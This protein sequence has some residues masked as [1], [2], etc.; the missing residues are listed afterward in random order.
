MP[1][2]SKVSEI[3]GQ[4][5]AVMEKN[6]KKARHTCTKEYRKKK[7]EAHASA[8]EPEALQN[9]PEAAAPEDSE[10]S[11][12]VWEISDAEDEVYP[13]LDDSPGGGFDKM[14]SIR[15]KWWLLKQWIW[16]C[17]YTNHLS[18]KTTCGR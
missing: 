12:M 8:P 14:Q 5:Q 3:A 9:A 10:K 4:L 2:V 18:T 7:A 11:T 1:Q 13:G 16:F 15:C 17:V 6:P